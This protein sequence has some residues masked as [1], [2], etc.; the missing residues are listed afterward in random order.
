MGVLDEFRPELVLYDAG[1]DIHVDDDLGNLLLAKHSGRL[2]SV[3]GGEACRFV[4]SASQA[5]RMA[6]SGL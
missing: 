3:R 6:N 2:G 4:R 5:A 1:V